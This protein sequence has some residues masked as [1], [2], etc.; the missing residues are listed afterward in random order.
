MTAGSV[1]QYYRG[2][3]KRLTTAFLNPSRLAPAGVSRRGFYAAL[4]NDRCRAL[5]LHRNR[6]RTARYLHAL[7]FGMT[8]KAVIEVTDVDDEAHVGWLQQDIPGWYGGRNMEFCRYSKSS[9]RLLEE[10]SR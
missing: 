2:L 5:L 6:F 1:P 7:G 3:P 8:M 4:N 10:T 9:S